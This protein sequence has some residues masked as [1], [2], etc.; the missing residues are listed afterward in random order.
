VGIILIHP[1][2][3]TIPMAIGITTWAFL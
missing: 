2:M 1:T 3:S